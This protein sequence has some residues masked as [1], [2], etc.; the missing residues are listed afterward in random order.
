MPSRAKGNDTRSS[1]FGGAF[2][3]SLREQFIPSSPAVT[4]SGAIKAP[5][6]CLPKRL[7][8]VVGS[9]QWANKI[10]SAEKNL[11]TFFRWVVG[12]SLGTL[13]GKQ[14]LMQ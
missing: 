7:A 14:V 4:L 6:L 3:S 8:Y 11:P 2:S 13:D 9:S 1:F 5:L 12:R 10:T